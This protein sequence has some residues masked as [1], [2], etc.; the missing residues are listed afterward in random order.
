MDQAISDELKRLI[1][2]GKGSEIR[3][4]LL[5]EQQIDLACFINC[6]GK[7]TAAQISKIRKV[8]IQNASSKLSTLHKK[9]YLI[10]EAYSAESG[11][12]EFGYMVSE[13]F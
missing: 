4:L 10:R 11:G 7:T 3:S 9:G 6:R 13:D 8:S 12:I 1:I 2:N 5:T